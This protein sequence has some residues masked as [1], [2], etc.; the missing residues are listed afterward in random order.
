LDLISAIRNDGEFPDRG[1][2]VIS[3][4]VRAVCVS[5]MREKA[6]LADG[7]HKTK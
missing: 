4:E 5:T 3:S 6:G 7:K 2:K 1:G